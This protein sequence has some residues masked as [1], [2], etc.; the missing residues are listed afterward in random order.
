MQFLPL[1]YA[2]QCCKSHIIPLTRAETPQKRSVL[3]KEY[4]VYTYELERFIMLSMPLLRYAP[5]KALK[6]SNTFA[7][8]PLPCHHS[9]PYF[10]GHPLPYHTK[11]QKR[12][13]PTRDAPLLT[14]IYFARYPCPTPSQHRKRRNANNVRIMPAPHRCKRPP[15]RRVQCKRPSHVWNRL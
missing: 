8:Y 3:C 9:R 12:G 4:K 6:R 5:T 1:F 13:R 10:P 15:T 2:L 14:L 11:A 7:P